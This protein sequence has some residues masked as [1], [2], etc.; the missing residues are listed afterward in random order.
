MQT[1]WKKSTA[2]TSKMNFDFSQF[3]VNLKIGGMQEKAIKTNEI[4]AHVAMIPMDSF[5]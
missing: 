4:H 3:T 1:K 5:S 2:F